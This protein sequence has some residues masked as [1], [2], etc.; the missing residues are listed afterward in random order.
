MTNTYTLEEV[1]KHN[2][3]TDGWLVIERKVYDVSP[4]MALKI[5]PGKGAILE[6]LGKDATELFNTRPMGD[7][8]PHSDIARKVL[9]KYV[10]GE[11]TN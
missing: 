5:H 2:T 6:G 4:Y 10:I 8:T 1:A 3:Y 11:L 9:A 7:G